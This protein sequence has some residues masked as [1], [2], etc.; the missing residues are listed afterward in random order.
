[1]FLN[2]TLPLNLQCVIHFPSYQVIVFWEK[3]HHFL[4]LDAYICHSFILNK[5]NKILFHL[6]AFVKT[7]PVVHLRFVG[8]SWVGVTHICSHSYLGG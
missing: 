6:C 2:N 5:V 3:I 1:M 7:H 4:V 8:F